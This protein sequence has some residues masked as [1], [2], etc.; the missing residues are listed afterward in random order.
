MKRK[1]A[2]IS[3]LGLLTLAAC[4]GSSSSSNFSEQT[5]KIIKGPLQ[6]ANVFLDYNQDGIFDAATETTGS[7]DASGVVKL[8]PTSGT[9]D[10]VATTDNTT[11]DTYSGRA[12][13]SITL[14]A[15]KGAEVVTPLTTL[16]SDGVSPLRNET[17]ILFT[18]V[19]RAKGFSARSSFRTS[20]S[21]FFEMFSI[22]VNT[23]K[24][25]I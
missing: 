22:C 15:P 7:T 12:V 13:S 17:S 2:A 21:C 20:T 14:T 3:P 24:E 9:Y 5:I 11:V 19:I 10:I 4:G 8:T 25:D 23:I 6:N 16:L 18:V 1:I